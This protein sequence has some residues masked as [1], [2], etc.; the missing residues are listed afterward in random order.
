MLCK[1]QYDR[2]RRTIV[3]AATFQTEAMKHKRLL[4]RVSWSMLNRR[5]DCD[6]AIQEALERAW[7]RRNTLRNPHS[8]R[9]PRYIGCH[10]GLLGYRDTRAWFAFPSLETYPDEMYLAPMLG[11]EADLSQAVRVK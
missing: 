3:D 8:F 9:T 1:A 2:K 10:Y 5:E 6:D 7:K 11:S 4:W